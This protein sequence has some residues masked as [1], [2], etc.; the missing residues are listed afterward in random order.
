[1]RLF[2]EMLHATSHHG[3]SKKII[4]EKDVA[5]NVST[6]WVKILFHHNI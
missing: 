1:M 4:T 2:V 5:C 3:C 6:V